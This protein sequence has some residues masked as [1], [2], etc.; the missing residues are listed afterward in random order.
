M[1]AATATVAHSL[2]RAA[3]SPPSSGSMAA[4][5]RWNSMMHAAKMSSVRLRIRLRKLAGRRPGR[6]AL[7]AIFADATIG[8]RMVASAISV[9]MTR[10]AVTKN[11][12]C[13]ES[14]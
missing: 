12:A 1:H 9:G 14:M 3:I 7:D 4:L 6:E 10:A 8:M 2:D 5:A 11:T 13:A